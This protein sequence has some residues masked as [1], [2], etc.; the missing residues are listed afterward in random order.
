[1]CS[2]DVIGHFLKNGC[3][4]CLPKLSIPMLKKRL[5]F[6][7]VADETVRLQFLDT[8]WGR[9][10]NFEGFSRRTPHNPIY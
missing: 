6:P 8:R 4:Q 2:F 1:M 3:L 9:P 5:N 7:M 10:P